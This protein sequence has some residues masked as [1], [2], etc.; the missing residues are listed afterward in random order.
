MCVQLPISKPE[1][2]KTE[3]EFT[4]ENPLESWTIRPRTLSLLKLIPYILKENMRGFEIGRYE[5]NSL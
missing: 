2:A 4:V 1:P 5:I 3:M